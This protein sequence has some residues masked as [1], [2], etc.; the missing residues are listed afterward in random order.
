MTERI[1]G[2]SPRFVKF[3]QEKK[4]VSESIFY[5]ACSYF[6]IKSIKGEQE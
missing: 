6:V 5:H 1:S 4:A 3:V 2:F